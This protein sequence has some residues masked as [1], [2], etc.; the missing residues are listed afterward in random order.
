MPAR[1]S[2]PQ[3]RCRK[4]NGAV[5]GP[6]DSAG[7]VVTSLLSTQPLGG[8]S[9]VVTNNGLGFNLGAGGFNLQAT[10]KALE[11]RG[12]VRT[13]AEPTLTAMS[14]QEAEFNAG[15]QFPVPT[16]VED[17]RLTFEF[18]DFGARLKFTPSVKSSGSIGLVVDTSVT[19]PT[20][21]GS[22]SVEGVTIP[23]V[24]ER[25][26]K[27]SVEL[28]AGQTLVIGGLLQDNVRQQISRMPGLGDIP[29]LGT[30]FR[31]RDYIHSQTELIVLVTPTLAF[32]EDSRPTLPPDRMIPAFSAA[33]S[34]TVS[35]SQSWWSSAI[36]VI[37]ARSAASTLTASRRPPSPTSRIQVSQRASTK[38]LKAASVPNSK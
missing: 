31:S 25:R 37:S 24:K 35:P 13:L 17:N 5:P 11:R 38:Q 16:G 7:G 34:S 20:P 29:I 26:A 8:A 32:P 21:E 30:L 10:L 19:E 18:K 23:G 22:L 2:K 33:I 15:G 14:G 1:R 9:Q 4:N 28:Q 6:S 3:D 12:A 27:T 36:V